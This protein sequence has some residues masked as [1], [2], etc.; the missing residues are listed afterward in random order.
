[1][2]APADAR[3]GQRPPAEQ[4]VHVVDVDDIGAQ[5]A[6]GAGDLAGIQPTGEQRAGRCGPPHL[7]A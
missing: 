7:A 2:R 5:A 4:R 6:H 3:R 1:M